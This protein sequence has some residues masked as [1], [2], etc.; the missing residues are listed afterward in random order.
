M[1][2]PLS[3]N[4]IKDVDLA[5]KALEIVFRANGS[6][7]EGID[8]RNGHRRNVAGEV[9]SISLGGS[10]TKGEGSNFELTKNMFLHSN[11]LKFFLKKK[12][13]ITEFLPDTTMFYD[14]KTRVAR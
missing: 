4:I 3:A 7:V 2:T 14:Y 12:H 6:A 13:N 10:R 8:A 1:G 11:L 5:L 9:K